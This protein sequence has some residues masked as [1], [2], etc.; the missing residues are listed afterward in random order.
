[1]TPA[2][3]LALVTVGAYSWLVM[4]PMIIAA[5]ANDPD[6]TPPPMCCIPTWI[7]GIGDNGQW[8][9]AHNCP[10]QRDDA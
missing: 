9:H 7:P 2:A 10:R 3:L 1:V 6:W 5:L 4:G 8:V